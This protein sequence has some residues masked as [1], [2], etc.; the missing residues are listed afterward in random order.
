MKS[1][2]FNIT[3]AY[4]KS[5]RLWREFCVPEDYTFDELHKAI[6]IMFMFLDEYD[7]GFW[8]DD[9]TEIYPY[10]RFNEETPSKGSL[11]S[12]KTKI[13]DLFA[14][15]DEIAYYYGEWEFDIRYISRAESAEKVPFV[16]EGEGAVV[17][18]KCGGPCGYMAMREVFTNP[19]FNKTIL[20]D[21][22][23]DMINQRGTD[24]P[25]FG[26]FSAS[27]TNHTLRIFTRGELT[28]EKIL[29]EYDKKTVIGYKIFENGVDKTNKN[30]N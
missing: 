24:D 27:D 8:F 13:K 11:D 25:D 15:T 14:K 10:A 4:V 30:L 18:E 29:E 23:R 1:L 12:A 9:K 19:R 26:H 20:A 28:V 5:P 7:Y 22:Y 16:I 21:Y 2:R 3:A 17:Y 6:Q